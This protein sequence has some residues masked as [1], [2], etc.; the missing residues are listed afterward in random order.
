MISPCYSLCF[1]GCLFVKL[2]TFSSWWLQICFICIPKPR[3]ND[4]IWL[5][6]IF[7]IGLVNP[8]KIVLSYWILPQIHPPP[9]KKKPNQLEG[10]WLLFSFQ[11]FQTLKT[12]VFC[13]ALRKMWKSTRSVAL[14][15]LGSKIYPWPGSI[16]K[17]VALKIPGWSS[18]W[19]W[20]HAPWIYMWR[21]LLNLW[22]GWTNWKES[23]LSWVELICKGFW[24]VC[25]F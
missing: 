24:P 8:P 10:G 4:P 9:P 21:P 20:R 25:F 23:E 14:H 18:R 6:H 2:R 15:T 12:T 16:S 11:T 13:L 17:E 1:K 5:A 19:V 22:L 7:Q 3:G